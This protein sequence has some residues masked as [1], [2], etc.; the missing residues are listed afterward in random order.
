MSQLHHILSPQTTNKVYGICLL[1]FHYLK[2][3]KK[4]TKYPCLY[5]KL[6]IKCFSK[7]KKKKKLCIKLLS[8][9]KV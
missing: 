6:C 2:K 9:K 3:K 8:S 4:K 1:Q 7:K 5:N